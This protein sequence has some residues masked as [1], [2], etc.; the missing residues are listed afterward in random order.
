MFKSQVLAIVLCTLF[1]VILPPRMVAQE[2]WQPV[3]V[4]PDLKVMSAEFGA[5]P[6]GKG[7]KDRK[8]KAVVFTPTDK[9]DK[10]GF[11]YGWRIKLRTPR[12]TVHVY[13]VWGD[14]A[15]DQKVQLGSAETIVDGYIY[16][17]W[18]EVGAAKPRHSVTV[19]IE[20]KPVRTFVYF[21]N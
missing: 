6:A 14:H 1:A 15:T 10:A 16:R 5:F 20:G 7:P 17:D 9:A 21:T 19:Y 4:A 18:D 11:S 12:K 8:G 13:P 2:S 3:T